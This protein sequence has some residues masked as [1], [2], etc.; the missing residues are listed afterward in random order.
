EAGTTA[1]DQAAANR[2]VAFA[3]GGHTGTRHALA[4]AI[5]NTRP[6][7][8]NP[9]LRANLYNGLGRAMHP[10]V[11]AFLAARLFVEPAAYSALLGALGKRLDLDTHRIVLDMLSE[12]RRDPDAIHAATLYTDAIL[13]HHGSPRLVGDIARMVLTWQPASSD[14]KRRLRYIF[15]QATIA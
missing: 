13:T 3:G 2:V 11:T 14:D 7:N 5:R 10:D 9:A 12:R 1:P 6:S 4:D 15:E 8:Q